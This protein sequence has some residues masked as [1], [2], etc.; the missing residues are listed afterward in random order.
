MTH[1]DDMDEID[2]AIEEDMR[3]EYERGEIESA[4]SIDHQRD[5]GNKKAG[6]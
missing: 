4:Q 6:M 2:A 3:E 5:L 1:A